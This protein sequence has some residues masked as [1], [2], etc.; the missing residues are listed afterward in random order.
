MLDSVGI[1]C[2]IYIKTHGEKGLVDV[3]KYLLDRIERNV[4][5][6]KSVSVLCK[7][8]E[9]IGKCCCEIKSTETE[10]V[11]LTHSKSLL[12]LLLSEAESKMQL[13]RVI[14]IDLLPNLFTIR[15]GED[16]TLRKRVANDF[17]RTVLETLHSKQKR[18]TIDCVT[19]TCGLLHSLAK[20]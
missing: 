8:L 12:M 4:D 13:Q 20:S 14:L 17:V 3:A 6:L 11:V 1:L 9:A 5:R 19:R 7:V 15:E 16:S 10:Q 18:L 2:E